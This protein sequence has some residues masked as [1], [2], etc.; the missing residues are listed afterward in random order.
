MQIDPRT[1]TVRICDHIHCKN[2]GWPIIHVCCNW[3]TNLF[4][5]SEGSDW[6][7]YCSNKTCKNHEG[8]AWHQND[9]SFEEKDL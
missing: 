3:D 7:G 4:P 1:E 5:V 8:E 2:C 9:L 6:W